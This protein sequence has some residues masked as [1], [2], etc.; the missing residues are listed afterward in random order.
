MTTQ[1]R[2]GHLFMEFESDWGFGDHEEKWRPIWREYKADENDKC[3]YIG[4]HTLVAEVPDD[5]DPRPQQI[6]A[7]EARRQ[8]ITAKFQAAI[9]EIN[10]RISKL[11]AITFEG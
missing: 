5:F 3:I 11:Q 4:E 2:R 1:T 6:A 9:T 10:A 7:L 8:E